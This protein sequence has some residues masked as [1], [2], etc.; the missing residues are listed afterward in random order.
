ME[1]INGI[2]W[3][4]QLSDR[5]CVQPEGLVQVLVNCIAVTGT[6][7]GFPSPHAPPDLLCKV[8][9]VESVLERFASSRG[10]EL[11]V[12][13]SL[14]MPAGGAKDG[15]IQRTLA[16]YASCPVLARTLATLLLTP[17]TEAGDLL[18]ELWPRPE[19]GD[20]ERCNEGGDRE[21]R[22]WCFK[23]GN[24]QASRK[25][26][27]PILRRLLEDNEGILFPK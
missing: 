14:V 21:Q 20:R 4:R 18:L 9:G 8:S 12:L 19:W 13:M 17:E 24:V 26:V 1:G 16:V 27:E 3:L 5:P 15:G 7:R 11:L 22:L 2:S 10:V 23:Q 25:Q 6:E